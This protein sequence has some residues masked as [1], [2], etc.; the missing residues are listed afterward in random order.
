MEKKEYPYE[1]V[2]P[3]GEGTIAILDWINENPT[4]V[5]DHTFFQ[6]MVSRRVAIVSDALFT[7]FINLEDQ[8]NWEIENQ[9]VPKK[10]SNGWERLGDYTIGWICKKHNR[11]VY[12]T[13]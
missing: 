7:S 9:E 3:K 5:L 2:L 6:L 4:A 10:L 8:W 12:I 11:F 1:V 13:I